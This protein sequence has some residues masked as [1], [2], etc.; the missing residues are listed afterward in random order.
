VDPTGEFRIV[1]PIKGLSF[2]KDLTTKLKVR[3]CL[4]PME[5]ERLWENVIRTIRKNWFSHPV[6]SGF[7]RKVIRDHK[8][9]EYNE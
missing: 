7:L 9:V 8:K 5:R 2:V 1:F 4:A 6:S 3:K